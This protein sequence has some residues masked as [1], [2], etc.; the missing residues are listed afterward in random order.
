MNAKTVAEY[1][2]EHD[3]FLL[4]THARPDGDT[5]G[6]AGALCSA[7]RRA[8]KQAYLL[9]NEEATEKYLPFVGGY[10]APVDDTYETVIAVDTA[11]VTM[12]P[13]AFSGKVDLCIDHHGSNS[14]YAERTLV[15]PHTAA[16]GEV[17]L[18]V[19]EELCGDVS[20]EEANLLYI[21]VSTDTG[22]FQYMNTTADTLRAAAKLVDYG[23]E[24]G[25]LNV[26]FFRSV[27]K[28][29]IMLESMVYNRMQ[30][31][32][33]GQIAIALITKEMIAQ[34]GAQPKDMDDLANLA[35]RPEGV[36]VAVTVK[37]NDDG[38]SKL[39]LRSK[40]R[41]NV[42]NICAKFGGGGH[43]MAAGCKIAADVETAAELV[44][45]AINE[46]WTA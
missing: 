7:L 3:K 43:A 27:A 12:F 24:N 41:V 13:K 6:S 42:S 17:M 28:E 4:V 29:R 20:K 25:K 39:S 10:F 32:R 1:L 36:I 33:D 45:A 37:E 40:P 9:K 46:E 11:D 35:G 44:L 23:A 2:R 16:C 34:S 15:E 14:F 22:C 21:A 18:R 30:F 38:T 8:G 26:L 31:H 19:I 5:L